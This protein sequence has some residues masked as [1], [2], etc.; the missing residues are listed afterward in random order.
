MKNSTSGDNYPQ[1]EKLE[2]EP[3]KVDIDL[4]SGRK[5]SPAKNKAFQDSVSC[6]IIVLIRLKLR[7]FGG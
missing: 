2:Q 7:T 6:D 1:Y 3:T 5:G 4:L